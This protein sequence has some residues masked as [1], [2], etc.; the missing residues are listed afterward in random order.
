MPRQNNLVCIRGTTF[1][2]HQWP[3]P[4]QNR[5]ST[6]AQPVD[7]QPGNGPRCTAAEVRLTWNCHFDAFGYC[8]AATHVPF[9]G[10]KL[11]FLLDHVLEE[12]DM[13]P[14]RPR[15]EQSL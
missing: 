6:R 4:N 5:I 7:V 13:M 8:S 12:I 1:S 2:H 14:T 15:K 9:L 3:W 11:P 10:Y